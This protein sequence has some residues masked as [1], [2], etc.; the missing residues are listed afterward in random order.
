MMSL[1]YKIQEAMKVK[2]EKNRSPN[3]VQTNFF[4]DCLKF[5]K[6]VTVVTIDGKEIKGKILEYDNFSFTFESTKR[7][8]ILFYKHGVARI[9]YE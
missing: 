8:K 1:K 4:N 2:E 7:E 3:F 9:V 6:L 5:D